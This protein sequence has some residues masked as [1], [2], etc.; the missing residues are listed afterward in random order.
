MEKTYIDQHDGGYWIAGS[1]ISLDSI[2]Y[3]FK[4][5]AAPE[6]IQRSFSTLNLEQVYGAITYYLA[7]RETIDAYLVE[8]EIQFEAD[9]KSRREQLAAEAPDLYRRI[10]EAKKGT[11]VR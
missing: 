6:N 7:H 11:L 9:A 10:M 2:V 5:G 3:Q 1:R 8:S 4:D